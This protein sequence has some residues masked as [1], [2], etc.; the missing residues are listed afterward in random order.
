MVLVMIAARSRQK[1]GW[2]LP[3]PSY[4]FHRLPRVD[5]LA[6]TKH[7]EGIIRAGTERAV[8]VRAEAT[9]VPLP[10]VQIDA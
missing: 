2:S 6:D 1:R 5:L 10:M 7:G 3:V 4:P 8:A 9:A